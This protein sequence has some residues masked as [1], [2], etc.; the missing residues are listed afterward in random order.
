M[1]EV[2]GDVRMACPGAPV[3]RI[4]TDSTL[5]T[6]EHDFE[7][8]YASMSAPQP[9]P[10]GSPAQVELKRSSGLSSLAPLEVPL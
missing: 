9:F 4:T 1:Y 3:Q 6:S 8:S 2:R 10:G 5:S 7:L